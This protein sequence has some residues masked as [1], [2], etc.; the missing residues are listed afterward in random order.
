MIPIPKP[1]SIA[2]KM[3]I[4]RRCGLQ[5]RRNQMEVTSVHDGRN[6]AI[7]QPVTPRRVSRRARR[8]FAGAGKGRGSLSLRSYILDRG[9]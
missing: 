6:C 7:R 1:K 2:S 5:I 9:R 8:G 4:P 3:R